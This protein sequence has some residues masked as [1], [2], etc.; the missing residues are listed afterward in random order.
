MSETSEHFIK[1]CACPVCDYYLDC[2]A[3]ANKETDPP[4]PGDFS[5]CFKCGALLRWNLE[6]D[7][8]EATPEDLDELDPDNLKE[9]Y[10]IVTITRSFIEHHKAEKK[11]ER[12]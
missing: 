8:K 7:M 10:R 2:T 11:A 4:K 3:N 6:M 1:P 5:V 12:N 9:V